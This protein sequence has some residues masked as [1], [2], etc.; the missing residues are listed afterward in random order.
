MHVRLE[1][2]FIGTDRQAQKVID[3]ALQHPV[4]LSGLGLA[5]DDL[6]T[7]YPTVSCSSGP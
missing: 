4:V 7:L 1:R 6:K 3:R 2:L 5:D